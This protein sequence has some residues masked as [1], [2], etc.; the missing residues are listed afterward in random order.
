V[1]DTEDAGPIVGFSVPQDEALDILRLQS[2]EAAKWF[3]KLG[4][5]RGNERFRFKADE[6]V[7][8]EYVPDK[9]MGN[10]IVFDDMERGTMKPV[11]MRTV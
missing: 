6:V 7:V 9:D 8:V 4:F 11:R 3:C 1:H 10:L 2:P 5:P